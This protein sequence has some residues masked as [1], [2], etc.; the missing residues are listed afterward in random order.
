MLLVGLIQGVMVWLKSGGT[1]WVASVGTH[2]GLLLV[3]SAILVRPPGRSHAV[4]VDTRLA[5]EERAADFTSVLDSAPQTAAAAP[6]AQSVVALAPEI[7]SVETSWLKDVD[8]FSSAGGPNGGKAREH[9]GDGG[10]GSGSAGFFGVAARGRKFVYVVDASGSMGDGGRFQRARAELTRSLAGLESD[11]ELYVIF[12]NDRTFPLYYPRRY[13]KMVSAT[14]RNKQRVEQWIQLSVADGGTRPRDAIILALSLEPDAIFFLSDG[15]F[16]PDTLVAVREKNEKNVAIHTI[17]FENR[18]G[19][20]LLEEMAR[21][22]R[23]SYRF[24]P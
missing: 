13:R 17:G 24:V 11:Q 22:N 16:D 9:G 19:E 5:D 12:F 1:A 15:E 2:A 7:P 18:Q 20:P 3:L 21:Q 23:G 4:V 6:S 8:P 14:E 10:D